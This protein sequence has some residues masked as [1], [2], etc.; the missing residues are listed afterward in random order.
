MKKKLLIISIVCVLIVL[1]SV[2]VSCSSGD[3]KEDPAIEATTIE[4]AQ[5]FAEQNAERYEAYSDG[6]K[7]YEIIQS[8]EYAEN[9]YYYLKLGTI[10]NVIIDSKVNE[11]TYTSGLKTEAKYIQSK[12]TSKT[13]ETKTTSIKERLV[14]DFPLKSVK[15]EEGLG[16]LEMFG[17]SGGFQ[18]EFNQNTTTI[19]NKQEEAEKIE[20]TIKE[21]REYT[22]SFDNTCPTGTYRICNVTNYDVYL[23]VTCPKNSTNIS[24]YIVSYDVQPYDSLRELYDYI[25]STDGFPKNQKYSIEFEETELLSLEKPANVI[26]KED[27][28]AMTNVITFDAGDGTFNYNVKRKS[29]SFGK[30]E[31]P[32]EIFPKN[33]PTQRNKYFVGWEYK[34]TKCDIEELKEYIIEQQIRGERVEITLKAIW[35][36]MAYT[37]TCNE[38]KTVTDVSKDEYYAFDLGKLKSQL[39]TYN[40]KISKIRLVFDG[41]E[42]EDGYQE[43]YLTNTRN[44]GWKDNKHTWKD[45]E[46][47]ISDDKVEIVPGQKGSDTFDKEYK[48]EILFEDLPSSSKWYLFLGA[49]GDKGDTWYCS[50]VKLILILS[51]K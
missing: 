11:V 28:V 4:V 19:T 32:S 47:I 13:I 14:Y 1:A 5:L 18:V 27:L 49:H 31:I 37:I 46:C 3:T 50:N 16:L 2:I 38:T 26:N 20:N 22:L 34:N 30:N 41:E 51:E 29:I 25:P 17:I 33:N 43:F 7:S 40:L 8:Y 15:L 9:Y 39:K 6:V 24:D 42:K 12:L 36:D 44:Y 10:K 45:G 23:Y 35:I 21:Q 48:K